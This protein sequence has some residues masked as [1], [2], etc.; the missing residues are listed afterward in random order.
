MNDK[1]S[2]IYFLNRVLITSAE[3]EEEEEGKNPS[4]RS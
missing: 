3:E 4:C 2:L 1:R